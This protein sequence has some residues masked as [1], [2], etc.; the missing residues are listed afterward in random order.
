MTS[1][2]NFNLSLN[3]ISNSQIS[4]LYERHLNE[5]PVKIEE[6]L[7]AQEAEY[8]KIYIVSL[9]S[10]DTFLR[11]SK[12]RVPHRK[13][14]NEVAALHYVRQHCA[15]LRDKVPEVL[16]WSDNTEEVGYEYTVMTRVN[17]VPLK[18]VLKL[19]MANEIIDNV[20]EVYEELEKCR[21]D[22]FG[23]LQFAPNGEVVPGPLVTFDV[24]DSDFLQKHLNETSFDDWN[25]RGPW[26]QESSFILERLT[27]CGRIIEKFAQ[28]SLFD[29]KAKI[30]QASQHLTSDPSVVDEASDGYFI[31]THRDLHL[32]N[33]LSDGQRITGILD[34]E[35]S[36]IMP[37]DRWEPG[38]TLRSVA[39]DDFRVKE[40]EWRE[41]LFKRIE[42]RSPKL[43]FDKS[44][45]RQKW[46]SFQSFIFWI[47]YK[48][49]EGEDGRVN[50]WREQ[51]EKLMGQ[52]GI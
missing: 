15:K 13:T 21:F 41:E 18:S 22:Q 26:K 46:W 29:I 27:V 23:G 34:W 36:A 17:G 9:S 19:E 3:V 47:V 32:A 20:L 40:E 37:L 10:G 14:Q 42:K 45:L 30:E 12:P 31:L 8:N 1:K 49:I 5:K 38:N 4:E 2:K 7:S 51:V 33:F 44:G 35:L 11:L 28:P 24:F 43:N 48:T 39:N 50:G 25:V 52:L 16:F 6:F